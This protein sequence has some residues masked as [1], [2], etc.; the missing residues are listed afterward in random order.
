MLLVILIIIAVLW[1]FDASPSGNY[2]SV[3]DGEFDESHFSGH[4]KYD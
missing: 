1:V 3:I 2:N 4:G